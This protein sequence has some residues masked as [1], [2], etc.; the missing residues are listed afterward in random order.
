MGIS[1]HNEMLTCTY[2][3]SVEKSDASADDLNDFMD[4]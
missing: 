3:I 2:S 4:V 1:L